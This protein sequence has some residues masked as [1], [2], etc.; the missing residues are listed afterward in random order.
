MADSIEAT[1]YY[2]L[3]LDYLKEIAHC[4]VFLTEPVYK[5]VD[6]NH[7]PLTAQQS[8]ELM[9]LAREVGNYMQLVVNSL[10]ENSNEK[11]DTI[12]AEQAKIIGMNKEARKNL[13]KSVKKNE[14]G[15]KNSLLVMS[16]LAETRNL[17]IYTSNMM[18]IQND[19]TQSLKN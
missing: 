2:I 3:T 18:K 6:N 11:L 1:H 14:I 15:T 13:I 4:A 10:D 8:E 16:I 12:V 5:H 9:G 17:L 19:F 7:K